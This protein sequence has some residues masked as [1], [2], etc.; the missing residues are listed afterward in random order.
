MHGTKLGFM[1]HIL[2]EAKF[3]LQ[4]NE[5]NHMEVPFYQEIY[6]K[7]L[8]NDAMKDK[9]LVRYLPNKEQLSGKLPERDF[10]FIDVHPAKSIH[11]GNNCRRT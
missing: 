6:V 1:R 9:L 3:F 5:V 7:N 10:F 4:Y 2:S 8:Y 11:E